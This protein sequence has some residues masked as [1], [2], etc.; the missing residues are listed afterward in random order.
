VSSEDVGVVSAVTVL[1]MLELE[2]NMLA[3]VD[4]VIDEDVADSSDALETIDS[5]IEL[6]IN[7]H[8][9]TSESA[10]QIMLRCRRRIRFGE[11]SWKKRYEK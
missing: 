9:Y 2:L 4:V 7:S 3:N 8:R 6:L 1:L 5:I 10:K 11:F